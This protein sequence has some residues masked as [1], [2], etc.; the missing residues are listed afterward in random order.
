MREEEFG[1][2]RQPPMA[3]APLHSPFAKHSQMKSLFIDHFS[4]SVFADSGFPYGVSLTQAWVLGKI[5]W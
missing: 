4:T 3:D 5:I 2:Y 1:G